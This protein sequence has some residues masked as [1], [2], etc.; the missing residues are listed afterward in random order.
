MSFRTI[1]EFPSPK[2]IIEEIPLSKE[3]Q[4]IKKKRDQEIRDIVELNSD[5]F[6]VVIG[7]CSAHDEKAVLDY[8]RRLAKL[9]EE[10]KDRV[11]IVPRIYTNKPRTTGEGYKGML[12]QPDPKEEPN[13]LGGLKAIRKMHI[14]VIEE[15][16][17]TS[18]DEMLYPENLPYLDDL[19]SYIAVGA[20]SVEN[21]QHR[22]VASG[23][24]IPV[25]MK[26]PTSG[27]FNVMFNSVQAAQNPH[28][29]LY[30]N[31]EV[32]TSSNLLTH[33]IL[34]GSCNKHGNNIPNYH[35]ED[36]LLAIAKYEQRNLKNPMIVI[37][38][39]HD[40]SGK[41]CLQQNRIVKEIMN[42]RKLDASIHRYVRGLMIESFLV[43][44]RQD[45]DEG[46]YGKSITDPCLGWDETQ[47][48]VRYIAGNV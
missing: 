26:N 33:V 20:R 5:R 47:E 44:G 10:V 24:D 14:R 21:Q 36:I 38:T 29:F 2:E 13:L 8:V 28:T 42:N 16:G 15:S 48:L 1:K 40:N 17:L 3:L 39:N 43:G 22:L 19:L 23:V 37:D 35:F 45:I 32:T 41:Q 30:R 6:L 25:G 11:L 34:R 4:A 31:E 7:P 46:I 18:A 12:H 27:D 9:E